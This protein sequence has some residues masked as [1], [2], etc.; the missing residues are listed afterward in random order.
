M[1][2]LQVQKKL[3]PAL[4]FAATPF[5]WLVASCEDK[6]NLFAA[7]DRLFATYVPPAPRPPE[8][9]TAIR[10]LPPFTTAPV[11]AVKL[12]ANIAP[13]AIPIP[14]PINAPVPAP[15]PIPVHILAPRFA[16]IIPPEIAPTIA[17]RTAVIAKNG[18]FPVVS[19]K[20]TGVVP[21]ICKHIPTE[22]AL[23]CKS[24]AIRVDKPSG[25]GTIVS[26]LEILQSCLG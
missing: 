21:A 8:P 3:P 14:A 16:A 12:P 4:P 5:I 7:C 13:A 11:E 23:P 9:I 24:I 2:F 17:P 26:A 18:S 15:T 19:D 10:V 20:M 25:F 6:A 1:C 22:N